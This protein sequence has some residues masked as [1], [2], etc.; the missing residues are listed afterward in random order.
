MLT[1]RSL[2]IACALALFGA[3]LLAAELR[4]PADY[5]SIQ[6]ALDAAVDGDSVVV[7]PARYYEN[8]RFP[9]RAIHLRSSHGP[10]MTT[11]YGRQLG[12][13][14]TFEG[15]PT[16]RSILEGFTLTDGLDAGRNTAGGVHVGVGGSAVIRGNVIRQNFGYGMGHG[17][18]LF[19]PA[20]VLVEN[21][22]IRHNRGGPGTT[23]GGG[24]GGIGVR[25]SAC[26][27]ASRCVTVIRNNYIGNNYVA[28]FSSGGGI[29]I[30]G[31]RV[32]V[33]GNVIEFN[34]A[35]S[36]GGGLASVSGSFSLIEGNLFHANRSYYQ[37]GGVWSLAGMGE[38]GPR[39]INNTFIDNEAP[40]G[41][42]MYISDINGETRIANNLI[43]ATGAGIALQC[44]PGGNARPPP[45]T[46]NIVYAPVG[47]AYGGRCRFLDGSNGNSSAQPIFLGGANFRLH[48]SSPGVDQG[49]VAWS[50]QTTDLTGG[51]RVVDGDGDGRALIDI[52]AYETQGPQVLFIDGFEGGD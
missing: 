12:T 19:R 31:A 20:S 1:N 10:L 49:D 2:P 25:G 39:F 14:V 4:V 42:A 37:G 52:G 16:E 28:S 38:P 43:Q 47:D 45:L 6:A 18:S 50:S 26:T 27:S 24:G 3:E 29:Y 9:P 48:P 35:S 32:S 17:I 34:S 7:A 11:I 23:G 22:E 51:P 8:L 44:A 40:V 30:S 36:E 21:N 33:I 5:P 46:D 15:T 13:V 41:S